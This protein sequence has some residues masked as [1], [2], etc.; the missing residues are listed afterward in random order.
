[1]ACETHCLHGVR[2][3]SLLLFR[4]SLGTTSILIC[5]FVPTLR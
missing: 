4:L 5:G 1:M 2:P 3:V